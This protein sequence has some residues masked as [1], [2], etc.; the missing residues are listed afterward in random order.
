MRTYQ[1]IRPRE[2]IDSFSVYSALVKLIL[3]TKLIVATKINNQPKAHPLLA[4][5]SLHL[6]HF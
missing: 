5:S 2:G 4:I 6:I 1:K 3:F